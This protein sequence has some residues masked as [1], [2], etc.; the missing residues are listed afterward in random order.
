MTK[1]LLRIAILTDVLTGI[2][3]IIIL[4]D[5]FVGEFLF[6]DA[7]GARDLFILLILTC[8]AINSFIWFK[9]AKIFDEDL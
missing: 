2:A 7:T 3:S 4:S 1:F 9:I 5:K 8:C 6:K